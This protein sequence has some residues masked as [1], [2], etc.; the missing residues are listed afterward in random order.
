MTENEAKMEKPLHVESRIDPRYDLSH[1]STEDAEFLASF[2]EAARKR[3]IW[4]A[5]LVP[6][7]SRIR[8]LF[9]WLQQVDLRLIPMLTILYLISFL[10]RSNIG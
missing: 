5:S 8:I 2:S 7:C 3:V 4:K 10:D 6:F 9:I 1:L